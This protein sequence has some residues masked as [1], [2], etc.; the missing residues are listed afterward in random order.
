MV[1]SALLMDI[2]E[3]RWAPGMISAT[4]VE[5]STKEICGRL[6]PIARRMT[7]SNGCWTR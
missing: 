7:F 1:A 2:I 5:L 4:I 6:Q 3:E